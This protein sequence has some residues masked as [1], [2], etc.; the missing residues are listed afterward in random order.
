MLIATP[1]SM[2]IWEQALLDNDFAFDLET[3][4]LD[5]RVAN[6]LGVSFAIKGDS[7]YLPLVDSRG[8]LKGFNPA[9]ALRFLKTVLA[10]KKT[11]IAHNL[12]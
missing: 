10:S 8:E 11:K 7:G 9:S 3:D 4:S 6:I 12:Q 1:G 2:A 5:R